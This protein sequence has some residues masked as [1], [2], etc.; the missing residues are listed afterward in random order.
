[1][2]SK[3]FLDILSQR[4]YLQT[5]IS[6]LHRIQKIKSD[7]ELITKTSMYRVS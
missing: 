1:M 4:M 6:T 5:Q 3:F 2:H 7:R